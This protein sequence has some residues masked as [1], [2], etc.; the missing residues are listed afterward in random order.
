MIKKTIEWLKLA[1]H[2][3]DQYENAIMCTARILKNVN[4]NK[5]TDNMKVY[6]VW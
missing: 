6:C 4:V 5:W 1:K 2:F 3:I